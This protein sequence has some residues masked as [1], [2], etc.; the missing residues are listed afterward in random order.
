MQLEKD[1]SL[2]QMVELKEGLG[3]YKSLILRFKMRVIFLIGFVLPVG[4][5]LFQHNYAFPNFIHP[6]ECDAM[7][8]HSNNYKSCMSTNTSTTDQNETVSARIMPRPHE[9]L[10]KGN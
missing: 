2:S 5:P 6:L 3:N 7:F 9:K 8:K 4:I 10:M 1:K